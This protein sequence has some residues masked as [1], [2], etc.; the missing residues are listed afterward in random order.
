M[1]KHK[2]SFIV[3]QRNIRNNVT[4]KK[5]KKDVWRCAKCAIRL[6]TKKEITAGLCDRCLLIENAIPATCQK[7]KKILEPAIF[8]DD[9]EPKYMELIYICD[10]CGTFWNRDEVIYK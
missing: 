9:D 5:T 3:T 8:L 10:R 2:S 6:N 4:D 7:C 1:T